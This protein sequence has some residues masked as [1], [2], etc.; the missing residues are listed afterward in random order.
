MAHLVQFV[1]VPFCI[2][3][4][5]EL[6]VATVE[7]ARPSR[8]FD[9]APVLFCSSC[10]FMDIG[11]QSVEVSAVYAVELFDGVEVAEGVSVDDDI[12]ATFDLG[13][14]VDGK[15]DSLEE[16]DQEIQAQDGKEAGPDKGDGKNVEEFRVLQVKGNSGGNEFVLPPDFTVK[17]YLFALD[18]VRIL[19]LFLLNLLGQLLLQFFNG[20]NQ[21]LQCVIH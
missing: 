20:L 6:A 3:V 2:T 4:F 5:Q 17:A 21:A 18:L 10:Y 19:S 9:R 8:V 14:L 13:N 1:A 7:T 15:A 11:E 16:R 12:I